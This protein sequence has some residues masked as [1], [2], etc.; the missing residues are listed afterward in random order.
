MKK[1]MFASA[2]G[3]YKTSFIKAILFSFLLAGFLPSM[4]QVRVTPPSSVGAEISYIG[5]IDDKLTFQVDYKNLT[6]ENFTVTISDQ[7]G[8]VLFHEKYSES[9]LSKNFAISKFEFEVGKLSFS[10]RKGKEKLIKIFSV[11]T[12]T[13]VQQDVVALRK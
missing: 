2:P 8:N 12:A 10:V 9:N 5:I 4:A 6:S 13:L 7:F 3:F 11:N 1:Q